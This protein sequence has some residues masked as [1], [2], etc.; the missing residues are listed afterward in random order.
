MKNIVIIGAGD[1][2]REL[3]WLI[4]DINK[5]KPTYV[6]LG[7]LDMDEGKTGRQFYGYEVLGTEKRLEELEK[8]QD[9][10]AVIAIQEGSIRKK[11]HHEHR[12]FQNW[13]TIVHPSAVI[14]GSVQIGQGSVFFPQVTVSVDT[15]LGAFGLF[16]IHSM[17]CND[18]EVG[19]YVSVMSGAQISERAKIGDGSYLAAGASVYPNVMVGRNVRAGVGAIISKDQTDGTEVSRVGT[20]IAFF[21]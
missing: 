2:G 13:E 9:A 21:K 12:G 20:R 19:D 14:A 7:F 17:I 15:V 1:L 16:Y 18:C 8:E 6:I 5:V 10:C 4:E 3:V 11:I